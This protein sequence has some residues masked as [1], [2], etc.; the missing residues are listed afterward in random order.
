MPTMKEIAQKTASEL[1]AHQK[2]CEEATKRMDGNVTA[3]AKHFDE[4]R[5][6]VKGFIEKTDARF[7][8]MG[9]MIIG[10]LLSAVGGL[11]M[12]LVNF[13]LSRAG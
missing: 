1:S 4:F 12:S 5:D 2:G 7:E 3:L 8:S 10:T 11:L 6:D 13:L 9:W